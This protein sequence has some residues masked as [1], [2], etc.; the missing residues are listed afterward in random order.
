MKQDAGERYPFVLRILHWLL[1]LM[2]AA[3][4]ALGFAAEYGSSR[5]SSTW[6]PLHFRLGLLILALTVLR[7]CLRLVL[8]VP[9]V[10][11]GGSP[12]RHRIRSW[13]H[14]LL[15]VA[16]LVLPTSGYVIW[17]WMGTDRTLPG[18]LEMPALFVP[19]DDETGRAVAWYLHV[20]GA[21]FLLALVCL[22]ASA[23]LLH[24]RSP[25][26]GLIARRMGFRKLTR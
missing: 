14:G 18:G 22:H 21:W 7:L 10:D 12:G 26:H 15:Y 5:F 17:V 16:V 1:A 20:Y 4:F 3:Q 13:V 23:A 2:L 9:G 6:L 25:E 24:P 11:R 8:P 19:P